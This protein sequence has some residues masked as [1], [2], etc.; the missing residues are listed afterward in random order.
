[1]KTAEHT[2]LDEARAGKTNWKKWGPYLSERQWGTVRE[3]Y[4]QNG[5]AWNFFTHDHARSRAY[6]WGEDGLAGIS[7][8]KQR[9]CFALSLWNGKDP[10]LKERLFGLTNSEGN[11]GE[12]VK[13]YYFYLDST[14]THSY[15]KYLY[16]Y[17][18]AA[19]PYAK[20]VDTNRGRSRQDNEEDGN[21]HAKRERPGPPSHRGLGPGHPDRHKEAPPAVRA[22]QAIPL[23]PGDFDVRHLLDRLP[24]GWEPDV[25]LVSSSLAQTLERPTPTG[26]DRLRVPTA[27]RLTDSHHT[28]R[29]IRTLLA[30]ARRVGCQYHWSTY[31]RQH[32]HFFVEAGLPRVF[33]VPGTITMPPEPPARVPVREHDVIFCGSVDRAHAYRTRL[34]ATLHER[35]VDVG[36]GRRPGEFLPWP[37]YLERFRTATVVFNCSLNGDFGRRVFEVLLA[38]AI[39]AGA[40]SFGSV[41]SPTAQGDRRITPPVVW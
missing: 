30:Y 14:P 11:H 6:R 10:I 28:C 38:G 18:Q 22:G 33:W 4:S 20:L 34:L 3:D 16:K 2:R 40:L 15:M 35:G 25:V 23:P 19:Y 8:D 21:R 1:M 7:D 29:P 12:D 37:A 26:L 9:L 39:V 24:P 17:P 5:D 41:L 27:L 36:L 32:L 13:E 31:D